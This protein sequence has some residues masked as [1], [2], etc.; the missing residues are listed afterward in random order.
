[1][2]S[3][4]PI[5][6]YQEAS[7]ESAPPIKIVRLLY[8]SAIRRMEQ[9]RRM[10]LPK[11]ATAFN[12]ALAKA[13][14]IVTELRFSLDHRRSAE[15]CQRLEGL[16]LFVEDQLGHALAERQSEA[17]EPAVR[18]MRTL[19]DAWEQVEVQAGRAA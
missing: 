7:L 10:Q 18:I 16:Y 11:D 19:L 9:A 17:L 14:A 8:Q 2:H 5:A 6:A 15:L 3:K 1:M 4:N 13:D 12:E